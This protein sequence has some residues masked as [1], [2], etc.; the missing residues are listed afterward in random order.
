MHATVIIVS[1][2]KRDLLS[3]KI[4]IAMSSNNMIITETDATKELPHLSFPPQ[5]TTLGLSKT[6]CQR[7][8][9]R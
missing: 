6:N 9:R 1:A 8:H 4:T 7:V 5:N 3:K 2:R